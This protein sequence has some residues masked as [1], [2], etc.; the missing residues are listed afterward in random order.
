MLNF[1]VL[2]VQYQCEKFRLKFKQEPPEI[3]IDADQLYELQ[4]SILQ[5]SKSKIKY[6]ILNLPVFLE[7]ILYQAN[8]IKTDKLFT[9]YWNIEEEELQTDE[10]WIK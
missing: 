8:R 3:A 10:E 1:V 4:D 2:G 7:N 5:T 6:L 9:K